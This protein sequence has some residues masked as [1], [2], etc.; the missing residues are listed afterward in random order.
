MYRIRS[1]IKKSSCY[2]AKVK[3]GD[4]CQDNNGSRYDCDKMY[5]LKR[6]CEIWKNTGSKRRMEVNKKETRKKTKEKDFSSIEK[7]IGC[8]V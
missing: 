4:E 7:H 6:V 1:P 2:G 8:K 3:V 5:L